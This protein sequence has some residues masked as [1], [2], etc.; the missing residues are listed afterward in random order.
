VQ[1]HACSFGIC[2][3]TVDGGLIELGSRMKEINLKISVED[4]QRG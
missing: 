4:V 2:R 3:E 1:T